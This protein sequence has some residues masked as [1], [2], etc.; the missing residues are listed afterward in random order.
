MAKAPKPGTTRT[1]ER[2]A[3]MIT[4]GGTWRLDPDEITPKDGNDLKRASGMKPSEVFLA[5]GEG[6][7]D[8][9]IAAG[10]LFLARRQSEGSWISYEMATEGLLQG[11]VREGKFTIE[12]ETPEQEAEADA[13]PEA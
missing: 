13:D 1:K 2:Q 4:F 5:L 9:G 3:L 6:V 8:V 10:L 11:S 12:L 7:S